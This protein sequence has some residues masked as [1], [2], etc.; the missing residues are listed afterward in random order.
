[1]NKKDKT[2]NRVLYIKIK[3]NQAEMNLI[4]SKFR[5]SGMQ[6]HYQTERRRKSIMAALDF[7]ATVVFEN[8]TLKNELL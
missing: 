1:M 6:R 5:E 3:V 8:Q 7:S 4:K 2:Q